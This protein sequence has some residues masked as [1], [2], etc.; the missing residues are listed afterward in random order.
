MFGKA[1]NILIIFALTLF[2]NTGTASAAQ[3]NDTQIKQQQVLK[4]GVF[5]RRNANSTYKMFKPLADYL[6]KSLGREV[7]LVTTKN[8]A[9]F[10]QAVQNQDFDVVHF[11]QLHYIESADA[12][13][14]HVIVMNEEYG[15]TTMAS[16]IAVRKD[17]NINK[18]EDLRG[19]KILFGGD[20]TAIIAY[21][22]NTY[23]LRQA[24]LQNGDYEEL[25]A[26]NPPN[27]T[28]AMYRKR[29][30]AAG[31]GDIGLRIPLLQQNGV[32]VSNIKL[33]IT[34]PRLPHLPWA[35]KKSLAKELQVKIQ[36]L[37]VQLDQSEEGRALLHKAQLTG[38]RV[39]S[40]KDYNDIRKIVIDYRKLIKVETKHLAKEARQTNND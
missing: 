8:F 7:K 34:S 28:I 6:A 25:F 3:N 24:G 31:I 27:A 14:Y 33:F 10:Q 40:D 2:L 1:L 19:K 36:K 30:D 15:D 23:Y 16:A 17:S 35:V 26:K 20:K 32:D 9:Q 11:N 12:D 4:L 18:I 13:G 22:I 38:L 21:V 5:P 39:A 37:L 29:V